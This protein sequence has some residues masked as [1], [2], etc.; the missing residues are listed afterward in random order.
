M[1]EEIIEKIKPELEKAVNYLKGELAKIRTSRPATSLIEDIEADIFSKKMPLKSLGQISLEQGKEII[2]QPWD[3]S[4][5]EPIEKAIFKSALQASCVVEKDRIRVRFPPLSKEI[6]KN[7]IR[8]LAEKAEGTKK[9][10]RHWRTQAWKEIQ[11]GF[12]Q[13]EIT[14][15]DKYRAKDK[16]QEMIDEYNKNVDEMKERKE[17]EIME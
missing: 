11:D 1:Y 3:V 8:L 15:D 2:I 14:E 6:R 12:A 4:Y 16:L 17:K 10:I 5:L 7:L 9:T 13:G